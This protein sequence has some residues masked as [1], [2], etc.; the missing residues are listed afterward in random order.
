MMNTKYLKNSIEKN[1]LLPTY[2]FVTSFNFLLSLVIVVVFIGLLFMYPAF[3]ASSPSGT[4]VK[5]LYT[6]FNGNQYSYGFKICAG[7]FDLHDIIVWV[8]SDSQTV[9]VTSD[10]IINAGKCSKTFGVQIQAEDP[11]SIRATLIDNTYV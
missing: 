7:N 9:T 1:A 4:Y 11:N 2:H 8:S 10:D 5:H 3:G 6:E